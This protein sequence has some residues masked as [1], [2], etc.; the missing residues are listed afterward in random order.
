M[1]P[2]RLKAIRKKLKLTQAELAD[3]IGYDTSTVAKWEQ[4]LTSI[5]KWMDLILAAMRNTNGKDNG[6]KQRSTSGK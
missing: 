5:P 2:I 1:T 3:H 4:G 6:T